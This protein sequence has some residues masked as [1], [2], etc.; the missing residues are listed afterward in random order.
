MR[1]TDLLCVFNIAQSLLKAKLHGYIICI[2]VRACVTVFVHLCVCAS[3]FVRVCV[4][5]RSLVPSCVG[6]YGLLQEYTKTC[7][8]VRLCVLAGVR[9]HSY[10]I[11][12]GN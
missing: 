3:V 6:G 12:S 8:Y 10:K 5:V 2:Y 11:S 9:V 4:C 7:V 1:S